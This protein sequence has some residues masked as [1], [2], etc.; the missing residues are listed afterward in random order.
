MNKI[1]AITGISLVTVAVGGFVGTAFFGLSELKTLLGMEEPVIKSVN[2][3]K[4]VSPNAGELAPEV[5]TDEIAEK[6]TFER[7]V[8]QRNDKELRKVSE[9]L[10]TQPAGVYLSE[11]VLEYGAAQDTAN[12]TSGTEAGCFQCPG[13]SDEEL[14]ARIRAILIDTPKAVEDRQLQAVLL[15]DG[16]IAYLGDIPL[17]MDEN[18]NFINPITGEP[19]LYQGKL[20]TKEL[21]ESNPD[22]ILNDA[23]G[24]NTFSNLGGKLSE[25]KM[26]QDDLVGMTYKGRET[27][28]DE[29][30]QLRYLDN[31]KPV[32][33]ENNETI[34]YKEGVGF[35]NAKGQASTLGNN[36]KTS[37]GK[38]IS[39][40]G[41][42]LENGEIVVRDLDKADFKGMTYDG[43]ET[44][45]D[46]NGQLR[47]VG[48]D[49]PVLDE[50]GE[51][52]FF[53]EGVGFVNKAGKPSSLGDKL[54]T[55]NG[56]KVTSD[57]KVI[58]N[59]SLAVRALA[60]SDLE[61]MT[62]KGQA[63]YVDENGQL[64]YV[65]S[66]KPVLDENG[67]EVFYKKGV[68]F[69]NK[70][71]DLSKLDGNLKTMDGAIVTAD[72]QVIENAPSSARML[73]E[74][75]FDGLTHNGKKVYVAADGTLRYVDSDE[76]VLDENNEPVYYKAGVGFVNKDGVKSKLGTSLKTASGE[77]VTAE[78]L[79]VP[80]SK[81]KF[82]GLSEEQAKMVALKLQNTSEA[83]A[84]SN[85]ITTSVKSG[86]NPVPL[87]GFYV[88]S[89]GE[90]LSSDMEPLS[91]TAGADPVIVDKSTLTIADGSIK[92]RPNIN[93][94]AHD[95]DKPLYFRAI[96]TK[97]LYTFDG[98]LVNEATQMLK[99]VDGE[100]RDSFEMRILFQGEPVSVGSDGAL[101]SPKGTIQSITKK[102]IYFNNDL[103]LTVQGDAAEVDGYLTSSEGIAITHLG[104]EYNGTQKTY[105]LLSESESV[106]YLPNSLI[107]RNNKPIYS[108]ALERLI[109]R[110]KQ[111]SSGKRSLQIDALGGGSFQDLSVQAED[112]KLVLIQ[113]D[114]KV[115]PVTIFV[116]DDQS[117]KLP[118]IKPNITLDLLGTGL[119]ISDKGYVFSD[120]EGDYVVLS[121]RMEPVRFD[122]RNLKDSNGIFK[123]IGK[124]TISDNP[125][126]TYMYNIDGTL[127]F[128]S[129]THLPAIRPEDSLVRT[130]DLTAIR[131][132]S[133]LWPNFNK[134][135]KAIMPELLSAA[136]ASSGRLY[137]N[138]KI[139][140][141]TLGGILSLDGQ[142]NLIS[143]VPNDAPVLERTFLPPSE[144]KTYLRVNGGLLIGQNGL[145]KM[146]DFTN[147]KGRF[148][149]EGNKVLVMPQA[150]L[151]SFDGVLV[152]N[153]QI[154][155]AKYLK[156]EFT[157]DGVR[158]YGGL[159]T[160]E[161]GNLIK[162][163]HQ[164][165]KLAEDGSGRVVNA[166]TGTE[167]TG[168]KGALYFDKNK[169]FVDERGRSNA[170]LLETKAGIID[171]NGNLVE[172]SSLFR[173]TN[174]SKFLFD[175]N[176][177]VYTED[178]TPVKMGEKQIRVD[179]EGNVFIGDVALEENEIPL[180]L[181][182]EGIKGASGNYSIGPNGEVLKEDMKP[183][184]GLFENALKIAMTPFELVSDAFNDTQ[185]DA[186]A[187][188]AT[189]DRLPDNTNEYESSADS[190]GSQQGTAN[191]SQSS[192]GTTGNTVSPGIRRLYPQ[193]VVLLSEI[194]AASLSAYQL[195][196]VKA[197][198]AK[199]SSLVNGSFK[200]TSVTV[201]TP[202]TE[203]NANGV[204]AN[205]TDFGA[206][207]NYQLGANAVAVNQGSMN[208]NGADISLNPEQANTVAQG[209]T[210]GFGYGEVTL[211]PD[212]A[213]NIYRK[214]QKVKGIVRVPVSTG[215]AGATYSPIIEIVSGPLRGAMI[216]GRVFASSKDITLSFGGD[217]ILRNGTKIV[218][219]DPFAVSMD[220]DT[221][222]AGTGAEVDNYFFEKIFKLAPLV[223]LSK[224]GEWVELVNTQYE[225]A[226]SL[227][228]I[229]ENRIVDPPTP[230]EFALSL[231]SEVGDTAQQIVQTDLDAL[232]RE[233]KLAENT[234]IDIVF[235]NDLYVNEN[236]LYAY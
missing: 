201:A 165:L 139:V 34:F 83:G 110:K 137:L 19:V 112:S 179:E 102:T 77:V 134:T 52:I 11:K 23:T 31:D 84:K 42:V 124:L 236:D 53:K 105:P 136:V 98:K 164:I 57:A 128:D 88:S 94:W 148:I 50:N 192:S 109:V 175:D 93:G 160:D 96:Q 233:I 125:S 103:G 132:K 92:W 67:E 143:N 183:A 218:G 163:G 39:A 2:I 86:S 107:L 15:E 135:P 48:S 181:T 196:D 40:T 189:E 104:Q 22:I 73:N 187:S 118:F 30:G 144:Y 180:V 71:G 177:N 150:S 156:P 101:L 63:T 26:T 17:F 7:E 115:D 95:N 55:R 133:S 46:E 108:N 100:L 211:V 214:G 121:N 190:S 159:L 210:V 220:P 61:G 191:T 3:A 146:N 168:E 69:V 197:E 47:Y 49:N 60:D 152:S 202:S 171:E 89:T 74:K 12:Q 174:F 230:D 6:E 111:D 205:G 130:D 131:S 116:H 206:N 36:L 99:V 117:N 78:G 82:Q 216:E 203:N 13:L 228:G 153:G 1:T 29:N 20:L 182:D 235:V 207:A 28:V 167:I 142:G 157:K 24:Q 14:E 147:D 38:R 155:N 234:E 41:T 106:Q 162:Q 224:A 75:D 212:D 215:N 27:Y 138:N 18:G 217:I 9:R 208:N 223:M 54:K 76:Q 227:T 72:A 199:L 21:L 140:T 85:N 25:R 231:A 184:K 232:T 172:K 176:G 59:K 123:Q 44:Y 62:Y 219:G 225:T 141:S 127:I 213:V 56:S 173:K 45:L 154:I 16:S 35:V 81:L 58:E 8:E 51:E 193:S 185:P 113:N 209:Q 126:P 169:G 151:L 166:L 65:G 10:M 70:S 145:I 68:G 43:N 120:N 221:G 198:V 226:N 194:E 170:V 37:D 90:L 64:R 33:D 178:G 200:T 79:V 91:L 5:N 122:G 161:Y 80:M 4:V 229:T 188:N 158:I 66:D 195:A 87:G 129:E 204:G 114:R 97:R 32:L 186:P 119:Y 222:Y 149:Y